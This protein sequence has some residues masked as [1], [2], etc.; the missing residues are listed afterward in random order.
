MIYLTQLV[1]LKPGQNETF[2]A[3]E[4]V[5]I[6]LIAKYKGELQLRVRTADHSALIEGTIE[7][8]YEI[9][10]V[11]FPSEA[12]FE[13]FLHDEERTQF[14]HLKEQSISTSMII[15]GEML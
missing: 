9:H 2:E 14:L 13:A 4:A 15:K 12:E 1:Y 8:P 3:F 10:I 11:R 7:M 6:P 5:A